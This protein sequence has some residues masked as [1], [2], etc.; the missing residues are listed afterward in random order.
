MDEKLRHMHKT[1]MQSP[2]FKKA[3]FK[4]KL[5]QQRRSPNMSCSPDIVQCSAHISTS[6]SSNYLNFFLES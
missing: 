2:R 1:F 5:K 6:R 4:S 3:V